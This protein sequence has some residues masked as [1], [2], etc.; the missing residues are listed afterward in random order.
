MLCASFCFAQNG[1]EKLASPAMGVLRDNCFSCHNPEKKKGGLVLTSRELALKG[2]DSGDALVPGQAAKSLI[3]Q[4]ILPGSD[5]HMPPKRQLEKGEVELLRA[6]IEAGAPWDA[7]VAA[8]KRAPSSRPV[9]LKP[10]PAEY[11]PIL[12]LAL[13]PDQKRLAAARGSEV[14]LF[15]VSKNAPELART[16]STGGNPVFS[17]AWS[18]DGMSLA[19]AGYRAIFLWDAKGWGAPKVIGG[20]PGRVSAL[21]M[22]KDRLIAAAGEQ[23]GDGMVL[24]WKLPELMGAEKFVVH[25]GSILALKVSPN[26]Q[27]LAT[28]SSDKEVKLWD[29]AT[30]RELASLEGH[31]AQVTAVAFSPD[32]SLLASAGGDKE[33]KVWDVKT[34]LQVWSLMA[35]PGEVTDLTWLDAKHLVSACEDGQLRLLSEQSRERA[36]RAF[37]GGAD[38]LYCLAAKGDGK[39]I[40]A[41]CHDGNVYACSVASGKMGAIS[42]VASADANRSAGALSFVKDV[43]PVLSHAGC[44]AGS[45]HAKPAGQNGFKLSVFAYD[46]RSDYRGIVKDSHG[47]R[48][49]P[50]AAGESLLLLKPTMAVEH[51]GGL[52]FKKDS[53]AYKLLVEWIEQGMPYSQPGEAQLAGI[54]VEPKDGRYVKGSRQ[55]LRIEARY[56]DNSRRDVTGLTD[57]TSNEKAIARV[58]ERGIVTMGEIPGETAVICRYMGLVAVA[59]FTIPADHQLPP[60]YY[61]ALPVNNFID[62]LEYQRLERLGLA[63]SGACTDA[64]FLRRASLDAIGLLPTTEQARAF[65]ADP[66]PG[67]RERLVDELLKNP[68]YGDFWA[69]KWADLLRPNPYRVGVKSVYVLD[70]WLRDSFRQDKPYDQFVREILLAHGNTQKDGPAVVLRDR[71]E[72]QDITTLYSQIFLG[73][74]LECAK[75]HHHPNEKWSQEDFYSLAAFFGQIKR[76]GQGIS[77]PISGE[78][79][80]IWFAPGGE[81]RHPLTGQVMTPKPPDGPVEQIPADQDPREVLAD[82]MTSPDNPFFARAAVNR[83]WGE[84]MGR[85]IVHPV[86]DFRVSNPATN[87]PLL[88]ALA[89]D[90]VDHHYDLKHLIRTIMLSRTY[91]ASSLPNEHN[92]RDTRN[93]SRWYRRRPAAEVLL[94]EVCDLTGVR[95]SLQGLP[96]GS[97]A[98]EAWNY[99]IDSDF[100]DAFSRPN[101]NADPPCE[102]DRES[103]VVQALHLMN[104]TK[105]MAKITDPAGRAMQLAKSKKTPGEIVTEL[106]LAAYSRIPTEEELKIATDAFSAP[107]AT[108]ESATEDVMWALINSA[109]FVLNH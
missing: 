3:A 6:W 31:G 20:I 61:A 11:H 22:T 99:R 9:V 106:Y 56:S 15:D 8:A 32:S 58:D 76:K 29:L 19:A 41:G 30:H 51:G 48:I 44:N 87:Q 71:R 38:V 54:E 101:M 102:R 89:K 4:A 49:F 95:E 25:Q 88:D 108:R 26:G 24:E 40:Y 82:W 5:P 93:F 70:R 75:C 16:L 18:T 86:D 42:K 47:R 27:L 13:S 43:L 96:A 84:L 103:S 97:R 98:I 65:L 107:K 53:P 73:I 85:G 36:E 72:P 10:L 90:F 7:Q 77:A 33:V 45:C 12:A 55:P 60:A 1:G 63:P 59:R 23:G 37:P 100:L 83:V 34:H 74:R 109:E 66:S 104:S 2:G 57:F 17:L 14:V 46:P 39:T 67:K 21:V 81:V 80:F 105:L 69:S 91:Q 64:E 68:A 52:R 62:R 50:A 94:D 28:A 92:L 79:E 78:A 35:N